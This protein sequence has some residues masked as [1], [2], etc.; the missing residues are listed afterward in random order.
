[1]AIKTEPF[2]G[3]RFVLSKPGTKT[4][5]GFVP[6]YYC[7]TKAEVEALFAATGVSKGQK[8]ADAMKVDQIEGAR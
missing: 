1:M 5:P 7:T 3:A 8:A 4:K 2:D 6:V